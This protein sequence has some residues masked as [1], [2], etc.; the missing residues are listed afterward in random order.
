MLRSQ[1]ES[2]EA[3][4]IYILDDI[5][6]EFDEIELVDMYVAKLRAV[7]IKNVLTK[8]SAVLDDFPSYRRVYWL[9]KIHRHETIPYI[10]LGLIE[11]NKYA[12]AFPLDVNNLPFT[13]GGV[14]LVSVPAHPVGLLCNAL[15]SRNYW[16]ALTRQLT[17]PSALPTFTGVKPLECLKFMNHLF[18]ACRQTNSANGAMFVDVRT[19]SV[20][21]Y[22]ITTSSELEDSTHPLKSIVSTAISQVTNQHVLTDSCDYL[23]N[24]LDCYVLKEPT[25]FETM[26]LIH[27]RCRRIIFGVPDQYAGGLISKETVHLSNVNHRLYVVG[28]VLQEQIKE[29]SGLTDNQLTIP[30]KPCVKRVPSLD[31]TLWDYADCRNKQIQPP[32]FYNMNFREVSPSHIY[33]EEESEDVY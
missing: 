9:K 22:T 31:S 17:V 20:L 11:G 1:F 10:L 13:H 24:D 4:N 27:S 5:E 2:K 16:P 33:E 3:Q 30:E 15:R 8:I 18:A 25:V 23:C 29:L 19:L 6:S 7:D 26:L 12:D 32:R 14:Y 21:D 28:G